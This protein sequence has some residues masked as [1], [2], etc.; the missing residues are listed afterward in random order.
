MENPLQMKNPAYPVMSILSGLLVSQVIATFQVFFTN[1]ALYHTLTAIHAEGYLTV[2]N[3]Q[4]MGSL[5]ELSTAV[6]GG[7]FLTL[8]VGAG[9]SV[10]TLAAAWVWDRALRRNPFYLIPLLLLWGGF[11][12]G[13]HWDGFSPFTTLYLTVIPPVVFASALLW[14]P[15]VNKNRPRHSGLLHLIPIIILGLLWVPQM[16]KGLFIHIRDHL[17]LK[18][19]VGE[20]IVDFYY[21]YTLYPAEVLK[22]LHRKLFKTCSLKTLSEGP[23]KNELRNA[24]LIHDWIETKKLDV[25]L[26]LERSGN[27]LVLEDGKGTAMEI[28]VNEFLSSPATALKRFSSRIDKHRIFRQLTFYSLLFAFPITLYILLYSLFFSFLGGWASAGTA[29]MRS[30]A[31][32]FF[33]ALILLL[34]LCRNDSRKTDRT[35]LASPHTQERYWAAKTLGVSQSH[36]IYEDLLE[37]LKDPSPIVVSAALF[38]LGQRGERKAISRILQHLKISEHYYV[39]WYAY[40]ALKNLGWNQKK[41]IRS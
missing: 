13:I 30:V 24:L 4:T 3:C 41:D 37:L 1:R 15:P 10:A 9:I 5:L 12:A 17:L 11:T 8:T 35:L 34:P 21:R 40:K 6:C 23:P 31:L 26:I 38:S 7:L 2:P 27:L 32:C 16:E 19:P 39:Q 22:P 20:R 14:M 29:S 28:P 36:E 18:N 25:D 33:T